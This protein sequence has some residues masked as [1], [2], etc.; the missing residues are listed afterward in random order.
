MSLLRKVVKMNRQ[1]KRALKSKK[2]DTLRKVNGVLVNVP[3]FFEAFDI[4]PANKMFNDDIIS[5]II[6]TLIVYY[7][8]PSIFDVSSELIPIN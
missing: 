3:E 7:F 5:I 2:K 1:Q 4:T 8:L 6:I